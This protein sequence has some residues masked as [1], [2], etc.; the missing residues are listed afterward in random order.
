L[1]IAEDQA[2]SKTALLIIAVVY[3]LVSISAIPLVAA[4]EFGGAEYP[5]LGG[6]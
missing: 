3:L 4:A 5:P 6:L 1:V 2:F